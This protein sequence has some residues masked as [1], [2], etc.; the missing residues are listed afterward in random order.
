MDQRQ[1]SA[2]WS[3]V[4]PMRIYGVNL[5]L[6]ICS[7]RSLGY[8]KQNWLI[9][10]LVYVL[11]KVK[12][13]LLYIERYPQCNKLGNN[14]FAKTFKTGGSTSTTRNPKKRVWNDAKWTL[15]K[16]VLSEEF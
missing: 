2:Q 3:W 14:Q 7:S 13:A 5:P 10:K 11:D 12:N 16:K 6:A 15:F 8:I 1:M 9:C 4:T